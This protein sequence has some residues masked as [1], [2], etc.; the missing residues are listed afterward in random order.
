MHTDTERC[1]RAV[2]SK[3]ARFDGW[4]FTAVLTTRIYCRPSCPVVPPKPEN[5]VFY[6]SAAACQQAGY[7]ACKRCRPDTSPGSPEWNARADAVARAMRLIRDG[8]V[9]REGVPGLAARLGYSTRQI[10]RQLLAELGAGPLALARAQ[11]AQT[12]RVLIETT[13]LPMADVAFAAGFSSVRT[14]ND[15][16]REVFALAP[17]ELRARAT[18]TRAASTPAASTPAARAVAGTPRTPGVITL[19]LPYRAPLNPDN[20]F[21]HLAATAVPGV[22]EWRDGA[23]R[24]TLTLPHGHGIV[25][26][27][28]HPDH[29]ACRL[30]LTDLRDLTLAISRCRWMLDLDADPVAVDDQLRTD[31]LLAPLVD[32]APGRRVP[33]TVD[34]AEFAVR[35]VLGQQVSTAAARTHAARLVAAHGTLV[36]DPE[37]GL[38][39]LFPAPEALAALDPEALALP[40]SRRTTLTTLVGALADGS[41]RLGPDSDWDE[42]RVHL[43]RLP[44]FGPWTVEVIAMRALGDPDAFLPTDLGV[45]RAAAGLGLPSTPAA[46][47]A[48]AAAWRPWRAYAVQYLWATDSHPI[49][50][51]PA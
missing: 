36:D 8:I 31:P 35:A 13:R 33:R 43:G 29:I 5:M 10:E 3:D 46:L 30:S 26:L 11:R 49:N 51:L 50:H 23:Y 42:A 1:V 6:P 27:A 7:R 45:R 16:V 9:D 40:G 25:A 39:H 24:R 34:A 4:F 47:T 44:G 28:P 32:K 22:E 15:T 48:R 14:F 17:S 19:R 12:A 37:G 38:T 41:L 18:S 2:Q 21:G 20:L